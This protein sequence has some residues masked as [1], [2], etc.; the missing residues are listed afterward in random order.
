MVIRIKML[1]SLILVSIINISAADT[2]KD[3]YLINETNK[4][5]ANIE[6]TALKYKREIDQL[7]IFAI[8]Q[9]DQSINAANKRGEKMEILVTNLTVILNM[10]LDVSVPNLENKTT[11]GFIEKAIDA[12]KHWAISQSGRLS[13]LFSVNSKDIEKFQ[14]E[15]DHYAMVEASFLLLADESIK[16]AEK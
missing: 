10:A 1:V 9:K 14:D 8:T 7:M 13:A 5:L 6:N 11:K 4:T 2:K 16:Y 12:H 15:A 3:V